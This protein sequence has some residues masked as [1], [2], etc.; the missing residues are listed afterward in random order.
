MGLIKNRYGSAP[1]MAPILLL[2]VLGLCGCIKEVDGDN[3]NADS[4][5]GKITAKVENGASYDSKISTVWALYDA[6]VSNAGELIGRMLTTG[7]YANG[8]FS[9]D[10][11][12]IP[13]SFL[14]NIQTFFTSGLKIS[15]ELEYSEPDARLLD[16]DFFGITHDNNYVDYFVYA[17]TGSN[18]TICLFV[19]SDSDVSVNGSTN[20]NV[21][22][23]QGWNR[24]YWTPS[25]GKVASNAPGDL[26]WYLYKEIN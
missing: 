2:F 6:E 16:V 22:L 11:P 3:A 17:S 24:I 25:A 7:N 1:G 5:N 8:E 26:K 18:R 12:E 23:R 4:F 10:L 13:A 9:I 14:M 15:D 20:I 19:F 21:V